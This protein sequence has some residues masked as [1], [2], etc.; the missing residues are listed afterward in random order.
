MLLEDDKYLKNQPYNRIVTTKR[1]KC[2]LYPFWLSHSLITLVIVKGM[3]KNDIVIK[4][5]W[6]KFIHTLVSL[7]YLFILL[8]L[9]TVTAWILTKWNVCLCV[10]FNVSGKKGIV[11]PKGEF[12]NSLLSFLNIRTKTEMCKWLLN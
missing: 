8:F 6:V 4:K 9:C 10:K 3:I 1:L 11:S 2:W 7:F 12:H 5:V